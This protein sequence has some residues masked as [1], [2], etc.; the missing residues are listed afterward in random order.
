MA[1][2]QNTTD[3]TTK[4]AEETGRAARNMTDQAARASEQTTRAAAD[5]ARRGSETARDTL[6]SGL[7]TAVESF[8][9]VTDQFTQALGFARPQSEELTRMS[10][11]NI[12]AVSQA[13]AVLAKG[14]QEISQTWFGLAQDRMSKNIDALN[15]I[16]GCRSMQDLVVVQSELVRDGMQ[17]AIDTGRRVAELSVRVANEAAGTIQSQA[18][19]NTVELERNADRGRRVA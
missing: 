13:S 5:A 7:D 4:A 6:H 16:A 19:R 3:Q 8:Q 10:S 12:G 15:R 14:A 11:Q 17:Q 9:R 1:A 18:S 2:N